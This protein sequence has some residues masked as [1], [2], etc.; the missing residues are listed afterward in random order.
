MGNVTAWILGTCMAVV[1]LL[2]LIMASQATDPM[3]YY[4]GLGLCLFGVLFN[5]GLVARNS[6]KQPE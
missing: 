3:I 1:A 2:G 4:V 6:G 5:Y